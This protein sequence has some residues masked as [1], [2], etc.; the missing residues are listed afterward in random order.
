MKGLA[1]YEAQ[2]EADYI[3]ALEEREDAHEALNEA[4][5]H[6]K[7]E[8][9]RLKTKKDKE[10]FRRLLFSRAGGKCEYCRA[11]APWEAGHWHHI[12]SRGAWGDDTWE[13]AAWLCGECHGKVHAGKIGKWDLLFKVFS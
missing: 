10:A 2:K 9:K 7:P 6:P 13:N 4:H 11:P 12:R 3:R 1:A 5:P 8:R